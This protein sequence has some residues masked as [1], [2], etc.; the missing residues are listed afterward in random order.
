M[1]EISNAQFET[2]ILKWTMLDN[3]KVIV[4]QNSKKGKSD[5]NTI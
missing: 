2:K 1:H 4:N 3:S 5:K